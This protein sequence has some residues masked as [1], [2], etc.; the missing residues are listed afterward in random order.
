MM[1][2]AH[3]IAKPLYVAARLGIADLIAASGEP[4]TSAELARKTNSNEDALY[5]ALRLLSTVGVFRELE[6]R[7]FAQTAISAHL[8]D[9][10]D[11]V[12]PMVLWFG[13]PAYSQVWERMLHSLETGETA[14]S[15]T[16]GKPLF[17]Y[18]E[19]DRRLADVFNLAMNSNAK[20]MHAAVAEAYDF[21]A[22]NK[23]FDVGGGLGQLAAQILARTGKPR[24]GVVD[25]EHVIPRTREFI[26]GK[27]FADRCEF[28]SGSFF[29]KI[30][31]G[32]DALILSFVLHDWQDD[33]CIRILR[34]CHSAL[35]SDGILL[36]V[37]NVIGEPN[38]QDLGVLTDME[39]LVVVGGRERRLSEYRE[40]L[41]E[42][43]FQLRRQIPTA[44]PVSIL[45]AIKTS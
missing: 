24:L 2:A 17:E 36:I 11:S 27:G 45:E 32:A 20:S 34:N 3:L 29:E 37:E 8:I 15:K 10:P 19:D 13:D 4:P 31:E 9:G 28:H 18:L 22:F 33:E 12:R 39:M 16:H 5:R 38:Q 40:L 1:S 7:R 6:G 26:G 23:L 41:L 43:G 14:F 30:P 25:L 42:A 44:A 35:P 21:S